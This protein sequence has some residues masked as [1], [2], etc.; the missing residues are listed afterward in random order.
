MHYCEPTAI[1]FPK[2]SLL[3]FKYHVIVMETVYWWCSLFRTPEEASA[4]AISKYKMDVDGQQN[5][6]VAEAPPRTT[7][8]GVSFVVGFEEPPKAKKPPR[9]PVRQRGQLS[10]AKHELSEAGLEEKQRLAEERRKVRN[11]SVGLSTEVMEGLTV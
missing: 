8:Q 6:E 5:G 4:K 10:T 11:A 9:R 1:F 7:P 3:F 2:F